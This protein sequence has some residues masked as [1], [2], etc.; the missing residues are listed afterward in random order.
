MT[1]RYA[2]ICGD[3]INAWTLQQGLRDLNYRTKILPRSK[4]TALDQAL[5]EASTLFFTDEAG[6]VSAA[7]QGVPAHFLPKIY[8][9]VLVDKLLLAH[10]LCAIGENPVPFASLSSWLRS[11]ISPPVVLKPRYSWVGSRK[12]PRG[13]VCFSTEQISQALNALQSQGI[14]S[15]LLLVQQFLTNAE[16]L[17]IAGFY[18]SR[19]PYRSFFIATRKVLGDN[20]NLSTGVLVE[21]VPAPKGLGKRVQHILNTLDYHGPFEMEFLYES[22]TDQYYILELNPRFWMQHGLFLRGYENCLIRAYLDEQ[23]TIP[24]ATDEELMLPYRPMLWADRIYW[25]HT[26]LGNMQTL[27]RSYQVEAYKARQ[28]GCIIYG[29]PTWGRVVRYMVKRIAQR[30]FL[31]TR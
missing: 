7:R 30:W 6:W 28:R 1:K 15:E 2:T 20:R 5:M 4:Y 17:S 19:H 9:P 21:T 13:M 23:F 31:S 27:Y 16:N 18:D 25:L 12:L 10:H 11:C 14:D 3:Y 22:E 8:N 29:F 24:T 26:L